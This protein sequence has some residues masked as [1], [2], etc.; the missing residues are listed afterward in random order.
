VAF[1][2]DAVQPALAGPGLD[3]REARLGV[4]EVVE[5]AFERTTSSVSGRAPSL[6]WRSI[7][8]A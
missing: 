1:V 2:D 3:E 6:R 5:V 8:V 7:S 4:V